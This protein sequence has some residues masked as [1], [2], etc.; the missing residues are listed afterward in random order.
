VKFVFN[1]FTTYD[2]NTILHA[3]LARN[4]FVVWQK[5]LHAGFGGGMVWNAGHRPGLK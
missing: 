2:N 3:A 4:R 5:T 1:V